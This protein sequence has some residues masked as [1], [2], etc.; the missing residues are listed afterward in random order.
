MLLDNLK[1]LERTKLNLA[2]KIFPVKSVEI[3]LLDKL[4]IL[5]KETKVNQ[6]SI[7]SILLPNFI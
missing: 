3:F 7:P 5:L 2:N 4:E 1:F 6:I